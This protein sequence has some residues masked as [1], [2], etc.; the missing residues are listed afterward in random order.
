MKG[1]AT[2]EQMAALAAAERHGLRPL[3]PRADDQA[4]RGRRGNGRGAHGAAGLGVR[5]DAVRVHARRHE[6]PERRDRAHERAARRA[7]GRCAREPEARLRR[8]R[9]G[10]PEPHARR[11]VAE[12]AGVLRSREPGELAAEAARGARRRADNEGRRRRRREDEEPGGGNNRNSRSPLLSFANTDM[13]FRDDVMVVGS[14]HG[15]N[16]YRLQGDKRR[17]S[18]RP[19]SAPAGRATSRSSAIS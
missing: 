17:S 10:D 14:Y 16:V 9:R 15:F 19:S 12:A 6:R 11:L 13:A 18:C 7:L 2:P 8:R 5:A 4:P 3:V 1:M